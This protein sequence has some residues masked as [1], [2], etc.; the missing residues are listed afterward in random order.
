[1]VSENRK[2]GYPSECDPDELETSGP[3]RRLESVHPDSRVGWDAEGFRLIFLTFNYTGRGGEP[4]VCP[5]EEEV[6]LL[7]SSH[8]FL[9]LHYFL[10]LVGTLEI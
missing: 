10:S 8:L 1:M 9:L 4:N 7:S 6:S 3:D 5:R 2:T